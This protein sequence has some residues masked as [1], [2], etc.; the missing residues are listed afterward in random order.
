MI[1]QNWFFYFIVNVVEAACKERMLD[2]LFHFQPT[3]THKTQTILLMFS[4]GIVFRD[5][6]GNIFSFLFL[7]PYS[8]ANFVNEI[9]IF[10]LRSPKNWRTALT[11]LS[12][13]SPYISIIL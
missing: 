4:F 6:V 3:C 10:Y 8:R 13:H 2:R 9:H 12:Q 5:V 7:F 11:R 1:D